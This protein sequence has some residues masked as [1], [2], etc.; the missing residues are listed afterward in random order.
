MV[1]NTIYLYI[2]LLEIFRVLRRLYTNIKQLE[3]TVKKVIYLN[4]V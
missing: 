3:S 4:K 2:S 1:I